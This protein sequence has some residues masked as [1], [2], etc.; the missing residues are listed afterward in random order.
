MDEIKKVRKS[1]SGG[2]RKKSVEKIKNRRPKQLRL[3]IDIWEQLDCLTADEYNE[4]ISEALHK[5][6]LKKEKIN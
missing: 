2:A 4:I 3:N 6:F 5:F 1:G